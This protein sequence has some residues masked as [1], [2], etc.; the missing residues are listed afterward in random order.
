MPKVTTL[1]A[2][3]H[4]SAS[5]DGAVERPRPTMRDVAALAGVSLKTV[6]RVINAEPAVSADLLARVERAIDQLDYRP[7]LTASS[8]RRNDG[9]TA[10][11][12]LVLEDLA[13]PYSAAVTRAVEDAARPR[14]VTVVA[15]SVDE[16]PERERALVRE[17]VARRVDGLIVAPTAADQSYLIADRRAGMAL[18][19]VDR[20]PNHLDA[21][22][23]VAANRSGATDGVRHLLAGG[24]RRIGFLGD[25]A[26]IAT[27]ADR[28]A[29]YVDAIE[30]AG[31]AA[32]M[33]IIRRD[34]R[35]VDAAKAAVEELLRLP[36]PP[37]AIFAA[38]NVLGIGAFAALRGLH[39]QFDVALVGFDDFPLADLLDPGVTVVAQDPA[40]IGRL[41]AETL[42]RRLDGDRSPST[43]QVVPTRLIVRGSGEIVPATA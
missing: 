1:S 29:G 38:Q 32:D 20:P 27:A 19:F 2:D 12:G 26:T 14:R 30:R 43:V 5:D 28:F 6:S 33:T 24:H 18:V 9:K 25:L 4:G 35:S 42:F 13:N 31:L 21:D 3:R 41:A 39:R 8:L 23:V 17:F 40:A 36:R 10:T 22:A 7:N 16:D 34:L 15:G 37:T 11:V